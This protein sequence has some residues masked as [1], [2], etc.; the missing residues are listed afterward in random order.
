MLNEKMALLTGSKQ[1]SVFE[2]ET[3]GVSVITDVTSKVPKNFFIF[4]YLCEYIVI[5]VA[6]TRV[7]KGN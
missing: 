1:S 3:V 7:K 6:K 5:F 2:N 4:L